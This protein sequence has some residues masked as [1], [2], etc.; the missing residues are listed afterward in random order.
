MHQGG[1]LPERV[2]IVETAHILEGTLQGKY[3]P[4]SRV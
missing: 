1:T 2:L 3:E 4:L